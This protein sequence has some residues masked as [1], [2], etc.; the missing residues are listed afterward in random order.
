MRIEELRAFRAERDA[1]DHDIVVLDRLS[2]IFGDVRVDTVLTRSRGEAFRALPSPAERRDAA[3]SELLL[4]RVEVRA[5]LHS[6]GDKTDR[7]RSR[8]RKQ[9]GGDTRDGSGSERRKPVSV[10]D[11]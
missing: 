10:H 1:A 3:D 5:C 4:Q 8:I 7:R 11:R 2:R 6:A 9:A